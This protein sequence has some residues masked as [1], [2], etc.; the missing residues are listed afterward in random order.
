[1]SYLILNSQ[2]SKIA[3]IVIL[4]ENMIGPMAL[5]KSCAVV[6]SVIANLPQVVIIGDIC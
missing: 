2:N 3:L 5:H 6:S 1:M 4:V